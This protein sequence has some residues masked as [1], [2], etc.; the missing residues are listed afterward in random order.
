MLITYRSDIVV[1]DGS[2]V[3]SE[4]PYYVPR[5]FNRT[6]PAYCTSVQLLKR[7]VPLIN[8][9]KQGSID[10]MCDLC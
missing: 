10:D 2:T 8:L 4:F 6:V 5:A 3:L 1:K 9:V 7:T